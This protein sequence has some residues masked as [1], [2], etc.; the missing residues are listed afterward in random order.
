MN[1]EPVAL[2]LGPAKGQETRGDGMRRIERIRET[3]VRRTGA[4]DGWIGED[5]AHSLS[6][7]AMIEGGQLGRHLWRHAEGRRRQIVRKLLDI[8]LEDISDLHG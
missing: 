3:I 2:R 6:A 4:T 7:A 8:S 5:P 1:S